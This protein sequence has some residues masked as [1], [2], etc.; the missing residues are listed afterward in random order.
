MSCVDGRMSRSETHALES[1]GYSYLLD[2]TI[3]LVVM[4]DSQALLVDVGCGFF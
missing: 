1:C 4:M 2:R 3:V